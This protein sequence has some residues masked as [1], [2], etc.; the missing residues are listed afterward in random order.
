MLT[1]AFL[2]GHDGLAGRSLAC[3]LT[4]AGTRV[5]TDADV[6]GPADVAALDELFATFR[7][8]GVIDAMPPS[9]VDGAGPAGGM[10]RLLRAQRTVLSAAHRFGA[11]TLLY[12]WSCD[13]TGRGY[14]ACREFGAA[15]LEAWR[16]EHGLRATVVASRGLAGWEDA[17]CTRPVGS[18]ARLVRDIYRARNAH[19]DHVE[20]AGD[21]AAPCRYMSGADWAR[22]CLEV[23]EDG[24]GGG[25]VLIDPVSDMSLGEAVAVVARVAEYAGSIAWRRA[26]PV[27]L[28]AGDRMV[29]PVQDTGLATVLEQY[30][31]AHA[32]GDGT[33][34]SGRVVR[35]GRPKGDAGA[36]GQVR[37]WRANGLVVGFTNGCFDVLHAGHVS[38]LRQAR[39]ECDRLVVGLNDDASVSRLKGPGRPVHTVGQRAAVLNAIRDVDAVVVFAEDT[40]ERLIRDLRPDILVKGADYDADEV[41]G[42]DF[43]RARGGRVVLAR[44]EAGLSSTAAIERLA[45]RGP[46]A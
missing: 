18:V 22:T 14:R 10:D 7:P 21:P 12:S 15:L 23:L 8:L 5:R 32:A 42:A 45:R 41:V 29:R 16:R 33:V 11:E 34:G 43:V 28:P 3:A 13:E 31:R 26:A 44:L 37:T 2:A 17:A 1:R 25:T 30:C 27:R 19:A 6:A 9:M 36:T 35:A 40:P 39:A 20:V 4:S 24:T 46:R 38:L